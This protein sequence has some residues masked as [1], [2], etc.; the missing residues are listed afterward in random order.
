MNH[1]TQFPRR[2]PYITVALFLLSITTVASALTTEQIAEKALAATVYLEMKD[3]TGTTLGF[4]SGFFVKPNQIA[5]N[6]HVIEGASQGT[7]KLVGKDTR[8][9]IEGIIATDKD[10]DLAVL[11]VTADGIPPLSLGDSDTVNIGAKV[12]VAGNPKGLEGTFSDG[13]ISRRERYPKKRLQMT[14]PISPGSSGG[15]VLNSAGK[16]IGISVSV[17]R[18]L[19]AQNLNF[20]IPSNYL[21]ALLGEARPAKPLSQNS[22]TISAETYFLWGNA[23]YKLGQYEVAISDYTQAIRLKPNY[24]DAYY[25]RGNAKD[26][27]KQYA[28]AIAD[29]TEAIRLKP[30]YAGAYNNQ[31]I[32]KAE[33]GQYFLAISDYDMAIRLKPNYAFA[34]NNRGL[35]KD[36]LKQYAAAIADYT[37][38]I[39]LKP[40][41]AYA[42]N[43]RGL[44]KAELGQYFPAISDYDMAIRLKPDYANAYFNRGNTKYK[45]KQY[46]AAIADYDTVIVLSPDYALA[47]YNRGHAKYKLKQYDAAI[48]DYDTVIVLSPDYALAY[49]NRGHA[50]DALGQHFPAIS[51]YDV[52][53]RLKPDYAYAYY[54]RGI[55]KVLLGR[56]WEAKQD[57]RTALRLAEKAGNASLKANIEEMLRFLE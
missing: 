14:A 53:I 11:K 28:A 1:K 9:Q 10:N 56:T 7:A 44:A 55:A 3:N 46:D 4:G 52:A 41:Y 27:L 49:Y 32:A 13:L 38:A 2:L 25:N 48:A 31:G 36:A 22:R 40:D 51:D 12:Y 6:F 35:A 45:L 17:H 47:Y 30:N 42:Y 37:E 26:A 21:K 18:A 5:T 8:Y 34:Y 43:N 16:V 54:N 57:L 24:A 19:D 20:A 33:L 29:Y 15:P 39:R 50:K 23:N